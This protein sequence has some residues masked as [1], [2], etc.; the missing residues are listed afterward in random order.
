M[1]YV[2]N[3]LYLILLLLVTGCSPSTAQDCQQ[4]AKGVI[5]S[6]LVDFK[7]VQSREDLLDKEEQIKQKMQILVN[8]MLRLK[9]IE[10]IG[11]M[12]FEEEDH[13]MSN[14]LMQEM[15]RIYYIDGA[16]E[17]IEQFQREALIRLDSHN[18]IGAK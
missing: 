9:K 2:K 17:L 11:E 1:R 6:L 15:K 7:E 12:I 8:L 5:K 18:Q 13:A 3:M 14:L 16:R 10:E 4:E